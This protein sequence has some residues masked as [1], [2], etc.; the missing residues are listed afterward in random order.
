MIHIA[1]VDWIIIVF[2]FL[3][4]MGFGG[5]FGKY[6]RS[7]R[8]FFFGGQRFAWWI[9]AFSCIATLVGSY[10]FIKYSTNAYKYGFS[11][12][13]S[14]LNDW[15]W[16]PLMMFGWIPIIYYTRIR[17]IPEYF[18]RRFDKK[19][20]LV[21][22]LFMLLYLIGYIGINL[23]TM[24]VALNPIL[25]VFADRNLNFYF[26]VASIA[27]ACAVYITIGGQT[28]VIMTDLLQGMLLLA[29]GV[30]I[31]CIGAG[32]MGG[33]GEFW[34]NVP[35]GH[36]FALARFNDSGSFSFAGVF[37]Q[38]GIANSAVFWFMNQGI[39]MRFLSARSVNDGRKA[40]LFV[41]LVL[42][43]VATFAIDSTGWL[44]TAMVNKGILPPEVKAQDIFLNVAYLV[45]RPGVF[46]LILAA[47]AAALM[48]TV[49]TL[50]NATAAIWVNDVWQPYVRP[51][52]TDRY[53][54][55]VARWVSVLA[56]LAGIALVPVYRTVG[57]IY[58]AHGIFT[59][60]ITPPMAVALLM[61]LL[62]RRYTSR[63]AFWTL[64]GGG[65]AMFAG[66]LFPGILIKP[67]SHGI[68]LEGGA[69][70]GYKYIRAFYGVTCSLGIGVIITLLK[71][72]KDA[73][74]AAGLTIGSLR[75][76]MRLFKG[77]EPN[78]K[79][80]RVV[81]LKVAASGLVPPGGEDEGRG[82][83]LIPAHAMDAMNAAGGDIIY[84]CDP[85]WWYG[86]LKSL[87]ALAA[88]PGADVPEG[89]VCLSPRAM[90]H[91]GFSPGQTVTLQKMF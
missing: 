18:E 32:Y 52:R 56:T 14:Y 6:V 12:S 89:T 78:E 53:Y 74:V 4:M 5:Y 44:G 25:H 51:G 7:S 40:I 37:W 90:E 43:P 30:A 2:Y 65:A 60:T 66:M 62:W 1:H 41:L 76:L 33:F 19:T 39:I 72:Q 31:F 27:V 87:H 88:A 42:C 48:S 16:L 85:R 71:R 15:M 70:E 34:R 22:T 63:A 11:S 64:I 10:S 46:G 55:G 13:T 20:R 79:P 91:A 47:L 54:L 57:S 50:I 61:A 67:F 35:P 9:I 45:C 28:S 26:I 17:S 77:G 68:P 75:N 80:G 8:D 82:T 36:R 29:A 24:G 38:D 86:G 21:L 49:D 3:L 83:A 84:V 23:Y 59:A 73:D 81:R 69:F 58:E